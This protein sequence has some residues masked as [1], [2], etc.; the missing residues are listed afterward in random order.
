MCRTA[1]QRRVDFVGFRGGDYHLTG[2]PK[3]PRT[4]SSIARCCVNTQR[5]SK[6]KRN[7]NNKPLLS[8]PEV[9]CLLR[10]M[11]ELAA[12]VWSWL[13]SWLPALPVIRR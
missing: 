5:A 3:S 1:G 12:A 6:Q 4:K 9:S 7:L 10:W 2:A 8:H 13:L 11:M